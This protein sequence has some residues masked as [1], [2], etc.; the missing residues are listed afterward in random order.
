MNWRRSRCRRDA[1]RVVMRGADDAG[2]LMP[3]VAGCLRL[4]AWDARRPSGS[5]AP[6]RAPRAQPPALARQAGQRAGRQA[7]GR[8]HRGGAP[9]NTAILPGHGTTIPGRW[10]WPPGQFVLQVPTPGRAAQPRS[11]IT[12]GNDTMSSATHS[13]GPGPAPEPACSRWTTPEGLFTF[14]EN[15]VSYT[16]RTEKSCVRCRTI[17]G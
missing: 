15:V 8:R 14:K 2:M 17:P 13:A 3:G 1:H 7:P 10:C 11:G 5:P 6:C 9:Q 12:G 16:T 4:R